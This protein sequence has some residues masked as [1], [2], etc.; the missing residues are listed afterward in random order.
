MGQTSS[1][2]T[3][4]KTAEIEEFRSKLKEKDDKYCDSLDQLAHS[5]KLRVLITMNRIFWCHQTT[6]P[7]EISKRLQ[8][9]KDTL[10][11]NVLV[12]PCDINRFR[13]CVHAHGCWFYAF[14]SSYLIFWKSIESQ[15]RLK[16]KS[17]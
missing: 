4:G 16:L 2:E 5:D 8:E 10:G 7:L 13:F 17:E 15:T 9:C 11:C 3:A 12:A 14:G 6:D 1:S